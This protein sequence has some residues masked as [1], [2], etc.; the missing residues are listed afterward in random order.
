M[1]GTGPCS[2][3]RRAT[4]RYP[5]GGRKTPGSSPALRTARVPAGECARR[6]DTNTC[7]K[8]S[9][10]PPPTVVNERRWP[11]APHSNASYEK[12]VLRLP[13]FHGGRPLSAWDPVAQL[14]LLCSTDRWLTQAHAICFHAPDRISRVL[15]IEWR[16]RTPG[17]WP[18]PSSK[19]S[20]ILA[21]SRHERNG[22]W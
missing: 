14:S 16:R 4:N 12:T 5:T 2:V 17:H 15:L 7:G 21:N 8:A 18:V 3:P 10:T 19:S 20:N 9:P 1:N 22:Q 13:P 11:P 6:W